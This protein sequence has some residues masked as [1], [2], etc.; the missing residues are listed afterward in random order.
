MEAFVLNTSMRTPI[1]GGCRSD[2]L[3]AELNTIL[4]LENQRTYGLTGNKYGVVDSRR[5]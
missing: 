5:C 1:Y 3:M 4:R 2:D